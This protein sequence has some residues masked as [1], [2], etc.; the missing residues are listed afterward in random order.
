MAQP[1]IEIAAG[2]MGYAAYAAHQIESL[3]MET[4]ASAFL[5]FE[6][7]ADLFCCLQQQF[8]GGKIWNAGG[9]CRI[10]KAR[11]HRMVDVEQQRK[12]VDETPAGPAAVP[13]LFGAGAHD[14]SA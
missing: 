10:D 4:A 7:S 2:G 6:T 11:E 5:V 1:D 13:V 12:Q 14:V 9:C 3:N 8:G